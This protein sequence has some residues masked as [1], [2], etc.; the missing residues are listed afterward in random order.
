MKLF[1]KG[2]ASKLLSVAIFG[3]GIVTTILTNK[4]SAIERENL[5]NELKD[6]LLS[7]LTSTEN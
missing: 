2:N 5:K 7:E 6:E 1:A 3:L 4:N